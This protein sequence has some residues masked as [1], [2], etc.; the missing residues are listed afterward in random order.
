MI[1]YDMM[2][3]FFDYK[4]KSILNFNFIIMVIEVKGYTE[5][6]TEERGSG[7]TA[8]AAAKKVGHIMGQGRINTLEPE[9]ARS[10]LEDNWFTVVHSNMA[11]YEKDGI[12]TKWVCLHFPE[13]DEDNLGIR[14]S[15][16]LQSPKIGIFT[17]IANVS[18]FEDGRILVEGN[19]TEHEWPV[20]MRISPE[21]EVDVIYEMKELR[22]HQDMR[23]RFQDKDE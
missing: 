19:T 20:E 17:K 23:G 13:N 4:S 5:D 1:W 21:W 7:E 22:Y 9:K 18:V 12:R 6:W 3:M 2:I 14:L 15:R 10:F 8:E 16:V 11:E